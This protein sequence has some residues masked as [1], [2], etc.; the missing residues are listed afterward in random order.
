MILRRILGNENGAGTFLVMMTTLNMLLLAFFIVLNSIAVIDDKRRLEALGSLLGTFGLLTSGVN[1]SLS[2]DQKQIN[3]RSIEM[4]V[5]NE[6][7]MK[8]LQRIEQIAM[9]KQLGAYMGVQSGAKGMLIY[10]MNRITFVEGKTVLQPSARKMLGDIALLL[11]KVAGDINIIGYASPGSYKAG[12]YPDDWALSYARAGAAARYII[13]SADI[14]P[15]RVS[16]AGYGFIKPLFAGR[17]METGRFD[18]RLELV[19]DRTRI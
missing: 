9:E 16:V 12:P 2:T 19:L 11:S 6:N 10:L 14:R 3:P 18:D 7:V 5:S 17:S 4:A 15:E 8:M 1:P 13:D